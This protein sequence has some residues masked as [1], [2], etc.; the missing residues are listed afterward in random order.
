MESQADGTLFHQYHRLIDLLRYNKSV[1]K[2]TLAKLLD[3]SMPTL[4]KALDELKDNNIINENGGIKLN[5]AKSTFVGI[6][7][8]SA[9][10]KLVFLRTDFSVFSKADFGYYKQE[11]EFKKAY[12]KAAIDAGTESAVR[13]WS[14]KNATLELDKIPKGDKK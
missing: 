3:I 13:N 1:D 14:S 8:G 7:I 5:K 10:T 12:Y 9:Q 6:S 11:I 4:Y 2:T